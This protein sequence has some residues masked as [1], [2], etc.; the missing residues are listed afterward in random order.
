[1]KRVGLVLIV[2]GALCSGFASHAAVAA[3]VYTCT[4]GAIPTGTYSTLLVTGSC[5]IPAGATVTVTGNVTIAANAVLNAITENS[6]LTVEGNVTVAYHGALGL[7][8][9]TAIDTACTTPT[10]D[11]IDGSLLATQPTEL[12]LHSDTIGSLTMQGGGSGVTCKVNSR[13]VVP[14]IVLPPPITFPLPE[15]SAFEDNHMTGTVLVSGY[16]SCFL[17]FIR[18]VVSGTVT[19]TNN[20]LA[21]PDAMEVVTNTVTGTLVCAGNSPQAQVGDSMGQPNTVRG[22]NACPV[23]PAP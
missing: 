17:D 6:N 5:T 19:L 9:S 14:P 8:C 21:D 11:R 2:L 18:N 10:A 1:M 7:G 23:K 4:N 15:Y 20:K 3:G 13:L 22:V 16:Q 12:I